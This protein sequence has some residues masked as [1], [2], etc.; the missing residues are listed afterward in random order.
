MSNPAPLPADGF[1][2]ALDE[3]RAAVA[4][5]AQRGGLVAKLAAAL[6][7]LLETLAALLADF[8]AGRLA[9]V[10]PAPCPVSA[11]TAA[12]SGPAPLRPD[13]EVAPKGTAGAR[14]RQ[15]AGASAS[16]AIGERVAATTSPTGR[17]RGR[18]PALPN[19][20]CRRACRRFHVIR[21][22]RYDYASQNS[23]SAHLLL[24]AQIVTS[25]K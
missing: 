19:R 5:E 25:S 24:H 8:R 2:N 14:A 18:N 9:S 22:V 13:S 20:F 6:L 4:A 17:V 23:E 1:S 16:A 3:L 7:S 15:R 10:A 21:G 11:G 12:E